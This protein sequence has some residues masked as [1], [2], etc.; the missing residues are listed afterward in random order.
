MKKLFTL[1][2]AVLLVGFAGFVKADG[3]ENFANFPETS[4]SYVTGTF[5]G[6]DGSTWT[7]VNASGNPT[8][9]IT[10]PSPVLGKGKTPAAAVESGL[11]TGG[12]GTLSFKFMQAFSTGV[13]LDVMVNGVLITTVTS[14][15]EVGV[16]KESGDILVNSPG[17]FQIKFIQHDANGGQVTID[18]VAWTSY[19]GSLLPEPTNYPTDFTATANGFSIALEWADAT[20]GAQLPQFY[21]I[22]ASS[23]NNIQAPVDGTAVADDIDLS[24]GTG[25]KNVA[26]GIQTYTFDNLDA[27]K[28]YYFAIYPYTNTGSNADYKADGGAPTANAHTP[29]LVLIHSI[30][31]DDQAFGTWKTISVSGEEVWGFGATFGIGGTPCAMMSGYA[32]GASHANEDWLIS[33]QL[34]MTNYTNEILLFQSATK[35][36]GNVLEVKISTD[37]N[38]SG[39]PNSATWNDLQCTLSA[40]NFAWTSS[41]II[42]IEEYATT[43]AYIAYKYTSTDSESSTWELD[44]IKVYGETSTGINK[45]VAKGLS[46]Y[47]NPANGKL[48]V[49]NAVKGSKASLHSLTGQQVLT[50]ELSTG[51]NT[52]DV[53]NVQSGIYMLKIVNGTSIETYKIVIE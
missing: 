35:Y 26:Q 43:N 9:Q 29:N 45:P 8:V 39:D 25:A 5:V 13:N 36:T 52:F 15:G 33:P 46:I 53:S 47:P 37:Y 23:Q 28:T 2:V 34:N 19:G 6:N 3:L 51:V 7:Y 41:G 31:F 21:L 11:I 12:L 38:G 30:N 16:I 24:D 32:S 49:K 14:S 50:A 40:G 18:D 20:A 44:D 42:D 1:F 48:F 10:A 22:K 17:D 27:N 4:S